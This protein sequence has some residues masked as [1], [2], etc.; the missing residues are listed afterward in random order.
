M[1]NLGRT[2]FCCANPTYSPR[3]LSMSA[4]T[5]ADT[6]EHEAVVVE[7]VVLIQYEVDGNMSAIGPETVVQRCM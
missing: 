4:M 5:C 6:S 7:Q 1:F 2:L 3:W